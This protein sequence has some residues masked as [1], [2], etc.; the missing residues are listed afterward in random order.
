MQSDTT[1]VS[2]V[3]AFLKSIYYNRYTW[4]KTLHWKLNK[5]IP[6]GMYK[7]NFEAIN[8]ALNRRII[9]PE[10]ECDHLHNHDQSDALDLGKRLLGYVYFKNFYVWSWL[11]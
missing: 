9:K 10:M 1:V 6:F 8:L 2:I 4:P 3:A 5:V 11:P 7:Y